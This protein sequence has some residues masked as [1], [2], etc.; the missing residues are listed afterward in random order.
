MDTQ[1]D[2]LAKGSPLKNVFFLGYP[3]SML[4]L[5]GCMPRKGDYHRKNTRYHNKKK[6]T[7]HEFVDFL[8]GNINL[9]HLFF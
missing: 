5:R 4:N 6:Q 1:H 8:L 2:V 9:A 3:V 7:V